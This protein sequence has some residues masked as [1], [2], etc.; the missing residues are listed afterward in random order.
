MNCAVSMA[1]HHDL[2][3]GLSSRVPGTPGQ[4]PGQTQHNSFEYALS[5][6][7]RQSSGFN[8]DRM[9]HLLRLSTLTLFTLFVSLRESQ[10]EAMR[11]RVSQLKQRMRAEEEAIKDMRFKMK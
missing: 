8:S 9:L 10:M 2:V 5:H 11:S 6:V 4:V 7:T 3:N 1:T